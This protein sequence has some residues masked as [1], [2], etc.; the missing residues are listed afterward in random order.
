MLDD[1]LL[2]DETAIILYLSPMM[3]NGLNMIQTQSIT[4]LDSLVVIYV[5]IYIFY[6]VAVIAVQCLFWSIFITIMEKDLLKSKGMLRIL[7][8]GFLVRMQATIGGKK[9]TKSFFGKLN[10][11]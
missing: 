10:E 6:I 9:K 8:C 7:P 1:L 3:L 5:I 2:Q 11:F 4:Y